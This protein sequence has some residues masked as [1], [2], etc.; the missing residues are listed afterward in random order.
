MHY[1]EAE[2]RNIRGQATC[3]EV[4]DLHDEGIKARPLPLPDPDKL[5]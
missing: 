5:N 1:G 3:D 4:R 2:E